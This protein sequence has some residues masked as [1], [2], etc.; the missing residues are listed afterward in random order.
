[1]L[2]NSWS[3][4]N[5]VAPHASANT[6]ATTITAVPVGSDSDPELAAVKAAADQ[7]TASVAALEASV[8]APNKE[9]PGIAG[10][11][12]GNSRVAATVIGAAL[13]LT[14]VGALVADSALANLPSAMQGGLTH[15]KKLQGLLAVPRIRD[16]PGPSECCHSQ[17]GGRRP[18]HTGAVD[19]GRDLGTTGTPTRQLRT[20][21]VGG[22]GITPMSS[23]G[24]TV[25]CS[26][27]AFGSVTPWSLIN[28]GHCQV[29]CR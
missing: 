25:R 20:G 2:C 1:M 4:P 15:D 3:W 29:E 18:V 23:V 24:P 26:V 8:A 6:L 14:A 19:P 22:S 5:R 7:F 12:L 10:A 13:Q 11:V 17:P 9:S 16:S 21:R 27:G 28:R